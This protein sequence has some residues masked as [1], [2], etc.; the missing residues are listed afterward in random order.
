MK[1]AIIN[2]SDNIGGAAI[3]EYRIM[4]AL[5]ACGAEV[6]MLVAEKKT[7]DPNVLPA[8]STA[9]IKS[10][11][12]R[13]R[14]GIFLRNGIRRDT[15]FKIDTGDGGLPLWRHPAVAGADAV[16]LG[17][18]NQGLLSLKGI[19]RIVATGKPVVWT[20][21]DMWSMTGICHHAYSCTG[22]RSKC[23][24]C[25]LLTAS[26]AKKT[27]AWKTWKM[28]KRA[29]GDGNIKFVSVSHWLADRGRE[30]SLLCDAGIAVIPNPIKIDK[31]L[32]GIEKND[33]RFRIAFGAARIDDEV[34]GFPILAEASRILKKK[35]PGLA[36]T[37]ELHLF[38]GIKN[39]A[40]LDTLLLPVKYHGMLDG[41]DVNSLLSSCDAVVSTSLY[42]TMGYTLLEGQAYG[43]VPVSF[44]RGGQ[45]DVIKHRQT[46]FLAEFE[47]DIATA[48]GNIA[49]GLAWAAENRNAEMRR[50]MLESVEERF[51]PEAVGNAYLNLLKRDCILIKSKPYIAI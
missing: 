20:M 36:T 3:A 26:G 15:L 30:S 1:I 16:M 46:G 14:L 28:K 11:F 8:A 38:G 24:S 33:G 7:D 18:I 27:M 29:Y 41:S 23:L 9:W 37:T 19:E 22:F 51:S 32:T 31:S 10:E 48:A 5:E 50:R 35:Y 12:L 42:E 39:P 43:A 34:K 21:H 40:L 17:W 25:P 6:T 13:E 47:E 45:R 2:K 49:D 44:G 4:K